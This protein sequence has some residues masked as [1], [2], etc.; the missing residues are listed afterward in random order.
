MARMSSSGTKTAVP[1]PT[2][3]SKALQVGVIFYLEDLT[4]VSE[5][6]D[7]AVKYAG[8]SRLPWLRIVAIVFDR[9][10]RGFRTSVAL[11]PIVAGVGITMFHNIR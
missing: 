9:N 2:L 11:L 3:A 5:E 4:D 10:G 8:S 7:D 1:L 6:S